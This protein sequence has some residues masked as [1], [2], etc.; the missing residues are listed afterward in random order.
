MLARDLCWAGAAGLGDP[1]LDGEGLG[2]SG[3]GWA[4]PPGLLPPHPFFPRDAGPPPP[5]RRDALPCVFG[6]LEEQLLKCYSQGS[7]LVLPFSTQDKRGEEKE[8]FVLAQALFFRTTKSLEI[9]K[10]SRNP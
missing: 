6:L 9:W 1:G 4:L 5:V 2:D 8:G 7:L 3:L 10:D